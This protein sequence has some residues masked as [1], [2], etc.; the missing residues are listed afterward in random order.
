MKLVSSLKEILFFQFKQ[1][2]QRLQ[3]KKF[4]KQI[5]NQIRLKIILLMFFRVG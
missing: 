4:L 5:Q 2:E 3:K 1:V